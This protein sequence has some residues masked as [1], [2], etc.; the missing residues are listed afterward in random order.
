[1]RHL[2][3]CHF[4]NLYFQGCVVHCLDLLLEDWGEI[5]WAKQIVK[6]TKVIVSFTQQHHSP[7]GENPL[8]YTT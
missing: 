1:V 7:L 4:P 2:L 8:S 5:T 3:I 6:K